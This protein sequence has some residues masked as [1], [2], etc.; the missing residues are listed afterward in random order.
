MGLKFQKPSFN[1]MQNSILEQA[2][3]DLKSDKFGSQLDKKNKTWFLTFPNVYASWIKRDKILISQFTP[4]N[5]VPRQLGLKKQMK[6]MRS[7]VSFSY[8]LPEELWS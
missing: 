6:K 5:E 8:L 3:V 7:L 1:T 4:P 2:K